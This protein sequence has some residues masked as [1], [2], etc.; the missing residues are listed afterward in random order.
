MKL[1]IE[2]QG[3]NPKIRPDRGLKRGGCIEFHACAIEPPGSAVPAA[4]TGAKGS[5]Q[6]PEPDLDRLFSMFLREARTI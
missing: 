5:P 1:L 6:R 2:L 3:K 4:V